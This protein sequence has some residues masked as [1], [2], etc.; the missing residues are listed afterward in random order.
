[1]VIGRSSESLSTVESNSGTHVHP[2]GTTHDSCRASRNLKFHATHLDGIV[3]VASVVVNLLRLVVA[4][5]EREHLTG[6][7]LVGDGV[8][9]RSYH[10]VGRPQAE[11][12]VRLPLAGAVAVPATL[13]EPVAIDA[14]GCPSRVRNDLSKYSMNRNVAHNCLLLDRPSLDRFTLVFGAAHRLLRSPL[15]QPLLHV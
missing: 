3:S 2:D 7:A 15:S 5:S 12:L 13:Q 10:E 14:D 8:R 11:W 6:V 1:M 4:S 9:R